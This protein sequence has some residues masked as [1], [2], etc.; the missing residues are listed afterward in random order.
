ME[1]CGDWFLDL[2]DTQDAGRL[3]EKSNVTRRSRWQLARGCAAA[4][5]AE[6]GWA[7]EL[8]AHTA[9]SEFFKFRGFIA[10]DWERKR[11]LPRGPGVEPGQ[12]QRPQVAGRPGGQAVNANP[13]EVLRLDPSA[14]EEEVV[15]RGGQ[16]RPRASAEA[17]LTALRQAVQAL[18][19]RPEERLLHAL[20]SPP[21]PGYSW[22]ALERLAA[23][24]RRPPRAAAAEPVPP[25]ELDL[26]EFAALLLP[27]VL[28]EFE[29][30]PCLSRRRPSQ[31][32]G[33]DRPSDGRGRVA[34]PSFEPLASFSWLAAG[35]L[36]N[37]T[38]RA[39]HCS[40]QRRE[41]RCPPRPC[42]N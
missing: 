16:L 27:L 9:L 12:R 32:P 6:Q 10:D 39:T 23:A 28:A 29:P 18:T 15:R 5:A 26:H 14:S 7:G 37:V 22:P 25:P 1:I 20:L 33:G 38:V 21:R 40:Q 42:P 30:H 41:R 13:F 8:A 3:A 35:N 17:T 36:E 4:A 31:D 19:G 11:A 34:T 24:C 2:Y